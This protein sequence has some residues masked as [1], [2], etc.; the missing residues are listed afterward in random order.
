MPINSGA[1]EGSAAVLKMI[2]E[3]D[4][5]KLLLLLLIRLLHDFFYDRS[6]S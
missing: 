5:Y 1:V 6:G 3:F 2:G 4:S